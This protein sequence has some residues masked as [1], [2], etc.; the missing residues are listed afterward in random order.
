MFPHTTNGLGRGNIPVP[1]EPRVDPIVF[2]KQSKLGSTEHNELIAV[3]KG[4]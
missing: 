2:F 3:K 1:V 4:P